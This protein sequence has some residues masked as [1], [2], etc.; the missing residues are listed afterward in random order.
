MALINYKDR[1]HA[2]YFARNMRYLE[3]TTHPD[4]QDLFVDGMAFTGCE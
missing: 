2:K 1:K 3:L 4:F